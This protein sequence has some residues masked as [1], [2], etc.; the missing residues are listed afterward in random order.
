ME[1]E[2]QKNGPRKIFGVLEMGVFCVGFVKK[3]LLAGFEGVWRV[4]GMSVYPVFKGV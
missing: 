3:F 4:A 1:N 2:I